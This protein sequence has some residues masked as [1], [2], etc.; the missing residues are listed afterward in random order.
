M[1]GPFP[2]DE[3]ETITM[4]LPPHPTK[5]GFSINDDQL[6]NLPY[7]SACAKGSSA[8]KHIPSR[9]RRQAF[10]LNINGEGPITAAYA[11]S[12]IKEVQRIPG[13]ILQLDL[14]K[15]KHDATTPLSLT[16]AMFDQLP[17]TLQNRPVISH[18]STDTFGGHDHFITSPTKP[19]KPKSF[20]QC[21]KGPFRQNWI[22]AARTSFE[23]NR[24]VGVFSLPILRSTL[25]PDTNV[26]RTLL[27]PDF[28]PTD[29]PN[30]YKCKVRDC[31]VGTKQVKG[32]DFP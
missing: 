22:A 20:F 9:F 26:F 27:V 12:L 25:P 21:L 15:R 3:I 18:A 30:I 32:V 29:I 2:D 1:N 6:L 7:I 31:I 11:V 16:R 4:Q 13:E 8:W 17:S 10:I 19:E 24:K 14:V 28:K 23:K 5:I